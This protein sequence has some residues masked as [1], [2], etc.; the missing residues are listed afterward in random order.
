MGNSEM[1]QR[2]CLGNKKT[3]SMEKNLYGNQVAQ[4]VVDGFTQG[5]SELDWL[6][7]MVGWPS[8]Q[9]LSKIEELMQEIQQIKDLAQ[10]IAEQAPPMMPPAM[11]ESIPSDSMENKP[12]I[13]P[14]TVK[15]ESVDRPSQEKSTPKPPQKPDVVLPTTTSDN[16]VTN[17]RKHKRYMARY[18]CII[19]SSTV[20]FRTFTKDISLGGVALEDPIPAELMGVECIIYIS[21][22]KTNRNIKFKLALTSRGVA[23]YF[24]FTDADPEF[25]A[26]LKAWLESESLALAA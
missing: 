17:R 12:H 24:A 26:E 25:T 3:N 5:F 19:R 16:S 21:S 4:R 8:W 22:A 20:T 7:W 2:W 11:E 13:A 14:V 23:K 18:R 6:V 9:P 1:E 10:V 15:A